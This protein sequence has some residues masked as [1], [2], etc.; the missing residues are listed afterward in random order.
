MKLL[1]ALTN[2]LP[3]YGLLP[4]GL[5]GLFLLGCASE[6]PAQAPLVPDD[7][8]PALFVVLT[9]DD[10]MTQ[11]MAMVLANQAL[12]QGARVRV[13]LCGPGA[14]LGLAGRDGELL[15][16]REVTPGQLLTR[17]IQNE[18]V[19]EVCAIFLPNTDWD[20]GDLREGVGVAQPA[21][22]AAHMMAPGVRLFTF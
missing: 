12:D 19:V 1:N 11:G 10:N 21:E 2:N 5:L 3:D 17:L 7:P 13:L 22:A 4:L 20:E 8:E 16:P 18:V 15:L 14:E 6:P 9:E